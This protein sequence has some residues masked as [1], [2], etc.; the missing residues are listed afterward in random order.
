MMNNKYAKWIPRNPGYVHACSNCRFGVSAAAWFQNREHISPMPVHG[1][2]RFC[3]NC[4]RRM[5]NSKMDGV[6]YEDD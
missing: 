4:G 3:P 6:A 2:F 5:I 1:K